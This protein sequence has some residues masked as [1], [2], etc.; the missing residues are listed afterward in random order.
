MAPNLATTQIA[1][2]CVSLEVL[3]LDGN[4]FQKGLTAGLLSGVG[5]LH[6]LS[7]SFCL[8]K[9]ASRMRIV[10]SV[11]TCPGLEALQSYSSS[12]ELKAKLGADAAPA[13]KREA[14]APPQ[15][16]LTYLNLRGDSLTSLTTWFGGITSLT[17]LN[18]S[19]NKLTQ[20]NKSIGRMENLLTLRCDRCEL[21]ELTKAIGKMARLTRLNVSGNKLKDLPSTLEHLKVRSASGGAASRL[22]ACAPLHGGLPIAAALSAH[23]APGLWIMAPDTPTCNTPSRT[24]AIS[25]RAT[26]SSRGG[27]RC[28]GCCRALARSCSPTIG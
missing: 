1:K 13:E 5:N 20:L 21:K 14:D 2:G 19:Q 6:T 27:P 23:S 8:K 22:T 28:S 10:Q 4:G 12:N 3:T 11:E 16:N 9:S 24:C 25:T 17:E 26:T 18:L 7:V 15:A